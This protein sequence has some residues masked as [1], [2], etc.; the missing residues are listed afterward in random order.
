MKPSQIHNILDLARV[1]RKQGRKWNPLFTGAPGLGKSEI[2]QEWCRNKGLPFVDLRLA[3]LE[4]P[5]LT[6]FP[7]IQEV[8]GRARTINAL[9]EFWPDEMSAPEGVLLLEEPNRGQTSVMNAIMQLLTDRKVGKY[10]LPP[11]WIIVGCI[12]PEGGGCDVNTMDDALKDRFEPFTVNYDKLTFVDYMKEQEWDNRLILFVENSLWSYVAPEDVGTSTGNKYI[13]PRTMSKVNAALKADIPEDIQLEVFS[14]EFGD[15]VGKAFYS[16]LHNE[17]PVTFH[18]ITKNKRSALKRLEKFADPN[19]CKNGHLAIT[20]QSIIED[21]LNIDDALLVDILMVLPAEKAVSLVKGL[22]LAR[23]DSKLIAE[24]KVKVPNDEIL[25]RIVV[26]YPKV[27]EMMK[28]SLAVK[29]EKSKK[30]E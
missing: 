15:N 30:K 29:K 4:A 8:N 23:K 16:F 12:N 18:D 14:A 11:G 9:P 10:T 2:V 5:D 13:S 20:E 25:D 27:N 19:N 6:G 24:G 7:Q 28:A 21:G 26:D 17:S 1:I 22:T 3:L